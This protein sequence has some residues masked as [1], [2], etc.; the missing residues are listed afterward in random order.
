MKNIDK[1][2]IENTTRAAECFWRTSRWLISWWN[3]W[4]HFSNKMILEGQIKD[5]KMSS[6]FNLISK[7]SLN[8]NFLCIFFTNYWRV[9]ESLIQEHAHFFCKNF[10]LYRWWFICWQERDGVVT[11]LN[12]NEGD[13]TASTSPYLVFI[14]YEWNYEHRLKFLRHL[15][16][17]LV[18][19]N[20]ILG[21]P[22]AVSRVWRKGATKVFKHGRKCFKLKTNFR[23]ASRPDW[24]PLGLRGCK[25]YSLE[26]KT[27]I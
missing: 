18:D 25:N 3:T 11:Q 5:A 14:W 20:F 21:D 16:C 24:L 6:F 19:N 17:D 9:W 8:I 2:R 13:T 1:S 7:H 10:I 12:V 4:Y 26:K 23:R 27:V 22:G 15:F